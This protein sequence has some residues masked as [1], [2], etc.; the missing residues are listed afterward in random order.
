MGIL[1]HAE[2]P[3]IVSVSRRTDVPAFY[4]EWFI[5]L[6]REGQVLVSHPF[7]YQPIQ[8]S[9]Q[10]GDVAGFVFW[11]KNFRPFLKYL[12]E[13]DARGYRS[14]FFFTITGL[15][16]VFEPNVISVEDAVT[17]FRDLSRRY[18]AKHVQWR[19]DPILL[20]NSTPPEYHIK[21]FRRLCRQLEGY[22]TRCYFSFVCVYPKVQRRM[23][24]LAQYGVEF[25]KVSELE[26]VQLAAY[27]ADIAERHGI[28]MYS[29]CNDFLVGGKI[30]KAH[31]VDI[32]LLADL[33]GIDR[34]LYRLRPTRKQ[35]GCYES[36]DI[37]TYNTCRYGCVYCY[38]GANA[39]RSL[40]SL[41]VKSI[42]LV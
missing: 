30:K 16:R 29:C 39:R 7:N 17:T 14:F 35:C 40:G 41:V 25:L 38:A 11:S 5:N 32:D 12:D 19:Y 2:A 24:R 20:T 23:E 4:G 26:K 10:S 36:V 34:N 22:T 15:P 27:L 9:L 28:T 8:V 1:V 6:V 31:C 42:L 13:I 3:K 21:T 37:G 18:S 33:F